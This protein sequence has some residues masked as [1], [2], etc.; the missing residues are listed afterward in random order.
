MKLERKPFPA[1]RKEPFDSRNPT[2]G[3]A[4]SV[5]RLRDSIIGF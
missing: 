4:A 1:L 3:E 2:T 5:Y